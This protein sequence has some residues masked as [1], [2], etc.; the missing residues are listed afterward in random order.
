MIWNS[1]PDFARTARLEN[2]L[3]FLEEMSLE[4]QDKIGEV[5]F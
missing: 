4:K 2:A 3:A 1:L 5:K